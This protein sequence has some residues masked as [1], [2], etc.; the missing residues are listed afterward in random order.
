MIDIAKLMSKHKIT[1]FEEKKTNKA[2]ISYYIFDTDK[3]KEVRKKK[4]TGLE[5]NTKNVNYI[6]E[7]VIPTL[8]KQKE[9]GKG[10]L[11]QNK[12]DVE[13]VS[14][15]SQELFKDLK[16]HKDVRREYTIKGYESSM[17]QHFLP[18]FGHRMVRDITA[19]NLQKF[20]I[21]LGLSA[22]RLSNI[23][24]PINMLFKKAV[25]MEIIE[26]NPMDSVDSNLFKT[27]KIKDTNS[28]ST[29]EEKRTM[30][31]DEDNN[32]DPFSEEEIK[33]ILTVAEGKFKNYL[34]I[35]FFTGMRPSELIYLE[36]KNV[37]FKERYLVIE[38]A[39]TGKQTKDEETLTKSYSSR[40]TVYLSKQAIEYLRR[41]FVL[42][43]HLES[44]VFL[45]QYSK[46]YK[47]P[48][49]FRDN[50]WKKLFDRPR[51]QIEHGKERNTV[52]KKYNLGIRYRELYNLRHSFASINL[53]LNRLPLLLVSK[54]LGH[55]TPEIT[56]RKYST[57]KVDDYEI[58]LEMLDKSVEH[59]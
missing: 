38:G 47:S 4:S 14:V 54:Q 2:Y 55:S 40:R 58:T 41:Q 50:D 57:Y 22:K 34:G 53:S 30:I 36:W 43:G 33:K 12:L 19:D 18:I 8:F 7:K 39:L 31:E 42:T 6:K 1:I 27:K 59:F 35:L 3:Q 16:A 49:S 29:I 17:N 24:I 52:F 26:K 15:L 37:D 44:K 25:R 13:K 28:K 48:D 5:Y 51:K 20:F 9:K 45:N 21:S 32:I 56:L 11:A 10:I 46:P 23:K